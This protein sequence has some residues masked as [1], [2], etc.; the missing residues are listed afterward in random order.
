MKPIAPS[1]RVDR[2]LPA[3]LII[4]VLALLIS[5]AA[6]DV[7]SKENIQS[8][9]PAATCPS[10]SDQDSAAIYL[11]SSQVGIR[12]I[13]KTSLKYKNSKSYFQPL[14]VA[15]VLIAG[16]PGT[17][18]V[19]DTSNSGIGTVICSA[20]TPEQWFIGGSG[21]VTSRGVLEVINSGLS[22]SIVDI[23]GY[24]SK[25]ILAPRTVTVKAN[26]NVKISLDSIVPG[27]ESVAVHVV[28][29]EGRVTSFLHDVR[30]KGLQSLGSDY[31]NAFAAPAKQLVIPAVLNSGKSIIR[32]LDPGE[33]N[34][35][36]KVTVYARDGSF[37]P[38][39]LDG[40]TI[41][42][43]IVT[44]RPISVLNSSSPVAIMITS[45]QPILASILT[46]VSGADFAWATA[47]TPITLVTMNITGTKPEFL[48]Q[49]SNIRVR[50]KWTD[51]SGGSHA[52]TLT[53]SDIAH[54][55][56]G[57]AGIRKVTFMADLRNPN[58]G[59][60]ILRSFT[61][62]GSDLAYLPVA[63]SADLE[64]STLPIVDSHS[65]SRG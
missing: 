61:S 45:D 65:L 43:G 6:P 62:S 14:G 24:T 9:Y 64:T 54:W 11:P 29:R 23:F 50:V 31:V 17:S 39:G 36:V 38:I 2:R 37:S 56:P 33:I 15:P 3:I 55:N 53:G 8:T 46:I 28:T 7:Q 59:S 63:Q 12:T 52:T 40:R 47:A 21:G 32:L 13:S 49:G 60:M 27:E 19:M 4:T 34:A 22:D 26:S 35:N 42:H 10:T 48:F 25:G 20:G 1:F 30:N 51:Q 58:Y 5:Y 57:K 44:D 18:I 41:V 16:N